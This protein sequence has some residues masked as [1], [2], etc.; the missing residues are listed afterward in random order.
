[1]PQLST[2]KALRVINIQMS[3]TEKLRLL[4][5]AFNASELT[6]AEYR[7][8]RDAVKAAAWAKAIQKEEEFYLRLEKKKNA[9]NLQWEAYWKKEAAATKAAEE[10]TRRHQESYERMLAGLSPLDKAHMKRCEEE[11]DQAENAWLGRERD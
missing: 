6:T 2:P 1:M 8:Q 7:K 10:A 11:Q 5:E 4:E 9:E 3:T